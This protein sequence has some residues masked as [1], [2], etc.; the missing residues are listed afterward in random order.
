VQ[1]LDGFAQA[2][3]QHDLAV[4][5]ALGI[6]AI[7]G[8]VGTRMNGVAQLGQPAQGFLFELVFGH[9]AATPMSSFHR[10]DEMNMFIF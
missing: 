9:A 6:G 2:E 4:V 5:G 10:H 1:A 7:V 3:G 8:D